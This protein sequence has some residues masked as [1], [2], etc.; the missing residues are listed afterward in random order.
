MANELRD[1]GR[2]A[3]DD[4]EVSGVP[5]SGEKKP[6]KAEIRA[7]S[8]TVAA[9]LDSLAAGQ[10]AGAIV[11]GTR[12][13]L[14]ANLTPGA[15][16]KA[17]V[18]ADSTPAYNGVYQKV[19]AT[20]TGSWTKISD[21]AVT[22]L[23]ARV[24]VNEAVT[25]PLTGVDG[26]TPSTTEDMTVDG[27]GLVSIRAS[28]RGI[29][30]PG[31]TFQ[32]APGALFEIITDDGLVLERVTWD[33]GF[34]S[35]AGSVTGG[36]DAYATRLWSGAPTPTGVRI[37][38][39][40]E[41]DGPGVATLEVSL[42][43]FFTVKAFQAP[44]T[45]PLTT[46]KAPGTYWR[47]LVFDVTGLT[48]GTEYKAR[49][50]VDGRSFSDPL[51]FRTTP[52]AAS[53]TAFRF[54]LGSC[55]DLA[56]GTVARAF[57][58]IAAISG[59]RPLFM[60]HVGDLTYSDIGVND[61]RLQRMS[62][63]RAFRDNASVRAML[64]V[65][66]VVYSFDDHDFSVND[67]DWDTAYAGGATFE[68]IGRNTR[69][70]IR[71]TTPIYDPVQTPK[72]PP[73][74]ALTVSATVTRSGVPV[75]GLISVTRSASQ[76]VFSFDGPFVAGD[77]I[78]LVVGA[79]TFNRVVG[80]TT[81]TQIATNFEGSVDAGVRYDGRR[82]LSTVIVTL[83]NEEFDPDR[84]ILAQQ[85]DIAQCRFLMPDTR[86]QRR[87]QTG[88][89]TCLGE[90][91]GHEYWNQTLWF[92]KALI[93][94]GLDGIKRVFFVTPTGWIGAVYDS[95]GDRFP[96]DQAALC[97]Y[98]RDTDGIPAVTILTGDFHHCAAD[99]GTNAD[100]S[101][102]GGLAVSHFMASPLYR[103]PLTGGG[104]FSWNGVNGDM[105]GYSQTYMVADV[106][107]AGEFVMTF[108]DAS[109]FDAVAG[110]PAT[111]IGTYSSTQLTPTIQFSAASG[112]AP[113]STVANI[114]LV[115]TWFAKAGMDSRTFNWTTSNGQSGTGKFRSNSRKATIPVTAP[116]SGS[117]TVTISAPANAALGGQTT[118][119][120]TAT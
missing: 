13:A 45:V 3:F 60:L 116:A 37:A 94:A 78:D 27:D 23:G 95:W 28:G 44:A 26:L 101:T 14:F 72:G 2:T 30:A 113:A 109:T 65:V 79:E 66:P 87:W 104:P 21:L 16:A 93:Q 47:S 35:A 96:A 103:S 115:S 92:R 22:S 20:G 80:S 38:C 83:R 105:P 73:M 10:G 54:V 108:Y 5:A 46:D 11:Y 49:V 17:E 70:A 74:S 6:K 63:T 39:D 102:G 48:P 51:T 119:T 118:F 61:I 58:A 18:F 34:G 69:R 107:S 99:D 42:D 120:L 75:A 59:P 76:V 41:G 81:T 82:S 91:R 25:Q 90:T 12:A 100:K 53:A 71:E 67:C 29:E 62:N 43:S 57:E 98:L 52:A 111:L 15:A 112:T 85:W 50:V 31:A 24:S 19:G 114:G 97:N 8:D 89:P 9:Y 33:Q 64:A 40:I 4:F 36:V 77:V 86:S 55:S 32:W 68:Q 106:T 7:W 56:P 117:I 110:T 88:T 84:T 1:L